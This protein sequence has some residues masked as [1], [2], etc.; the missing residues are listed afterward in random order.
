[1]ESSVSI[2]RLGLMLPTALVLAGLGGFA[3]WGHSTEWSFS[4]GREV[5]TNGE[6][7][8]GVSHPLVQFESGGRNL[9]RIEF[10]ADRAATAS[11]IDIAVAWES[12][13]TEQ[14]LGAG[15]ITFDPARLA[16]L[17]ARAGGV[18]R[19]VY[20]AAGDP[21]QA[22]EIL[23]LIDST[24]VGKAKAEF[25]LALAQARLR[26]RRRD[27]L[28]RAKAASS[29]A[30]IREAEASL[31]EADVQVLA[32]SQ[33]LTNLGL[34]LKAVEYRALPPQE[35]APRLRLLG[36][37]DPVKDLAAEDRTANLLPVRSSFKGV[38]LSADAVAGEVVEAGKTLFVVVDSSRVRITVNVASE[39]SR[40]VAISQRVFF[41]PDGS[42]REYP[43]A[44]ISI[45]AAADETTR[46]VPVRAEAENASGELRASTLGRGR[47]ILRETPKALVVPQ[48]SVH[49]FREQ[50]VVFVRDPNFPKADGAKVFHVR[51]VTT[52]GTDERSIEIVGGV[53]PGEVIATKGSSLLLSELMRAAAGR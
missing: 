53:S 40:R 12:A 46:A 7:R 37:E 23:A 2:R 15:E 16:R 31:K 24:E 47:I 51:L 4:R 32:A 48:D 3:Y 30:A 44:V 17:P 1:M 8:T 10:G 6:D 18:T 42:L 34:H 52:G 25:Q 35:I 41:R 20:K 28:L 45:G 11:A 38:V 49:R 9:A 43:A 13:L 29:P 14:V 26:E 50:A 5:Q 39:E 21:V 36:V 22:G 33:A 27:D 19:R